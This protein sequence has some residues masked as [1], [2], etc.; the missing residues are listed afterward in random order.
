MP[1]PADQS[2]YIIERIDLT[3]NR[4]DLDE[5]FDIR[6]SVVELN[7]Y[8]NIELPYLTGTIAMV[9]DVAFKSTIGIKGTERIVIGLKATKNSPVLTKNFMI[10][11]IKK[12]VSVNERTDVRVLTLIE[13][14]AYLSAIQ[15]ISQA[16]TGRPSVI[17]ES[18]LTGHLGK[19]LESFSNEAVQNKMRVIIP[20]W[21]PLQAVDW[22]RDR[23]AFSNGSPYF[24]FSTLRDNL[25]HLSDLDLLMAADAWNE[26]N[27]YTYGQ[28]SHNFTLDS[29][30]QAR[31]LFHVKSYKA[32]NIESTLKMAQSGAVGSKFEVMDLTSGDQLFGQDNFHSGKETLNNFI[33]TALNKS[34]NT[35][36][37]FDDS[38][39]IGAL[40][41]KEISSYPSKVFSSVVASRQFYEDDDNKVPMSGYHDENANA[42]M[43]KLKIKS[44]ALR[45][46]LTNNMFSISVPGQPYLLDANA[47]VGST[48]KLDYAQPTL[49]P[50]NARSVDKN[51]SGKFLIYRARHKFAEGLY[52][53]HM[54]IVKLTGSV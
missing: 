37:G 21:N 46:I 49:D 54:D 47:G 20:N 6:K 15:K 35:S 13:E 7:I 44:A 25:I 9:D 36:F 50:R 28:T 19:Y 5:V 24:L 53:T 38:L 16:Y 30:D 41:S 52:D 18:I 14:H 26:K 27:V 3:T 34:E 51:R 4:L 10:T 48:I 29:K 12:E 45:S 1:D 40:E 11:G 33:N 23:M 32:I 2:Q 42:N 39:L 8:E 17:I 22:L 43:Y 31:K